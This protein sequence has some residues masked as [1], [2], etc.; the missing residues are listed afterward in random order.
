MM[1]YHSYISKSLLLFF[2]AKVLIA[3]GF[4]QDD[5]ATNIVEI[6]DLINPAFKCKWNDERT[7]ISRSRA[8]RSSSI[9]GIVQN[10]PLLCCGEFETCIILNSDQELQLMERR[11]FASS[12]VLNE[13]RLWVIGGVDERWKNVNSS[14]FISLDQPVEDGPKLPI[15]VS[16][17]CMVQVDSKSIYLIG[18]RQNS[19][20]SQDTWIIDPTNSFAIKK[21]P[22]LNYAREGH[23]CATMR[24]NNKTF[25]V[26][27][28]TGSFFDE[29]IRIEI[30]DTSLPT[31]T[32]KIAEGI[33]PCRHGSTLITSPTNKGVIMIGGSKPGDVGHE[34]SSLLYELSGDSD[35]NLTWT[36]LDRKLDTAR[37]S[38][39]SFSIPKDC[40][41]LKV[42]DRK[43]ASSETNRSELFGHSLWEIPEM[44]RE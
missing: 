5:N 35:N 31:N 26:V 29:S 19:G 32:W 44:I 28:G 21:G 25:I 27:L 14:E 15:N 33:A 24:L 3:G 17:H 10:Q 4:D 42:V 6:I 20:F 9:G 37:S 1:I 40:I 2:L 22:K 43:K 30:L 13:T 36:K 7:S 38:H 41:P 23:S 8:E 16:H 12:V 18:G 11:R 34:P 39:V